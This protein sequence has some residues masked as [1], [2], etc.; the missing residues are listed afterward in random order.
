MVVM[1]DHRIEESPSLNWSNWSLGA[2]PCNKAL[3]S[4]Y[5]PTLLI[6]SA[7]VKPQADL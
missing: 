2:W 7:E 3:K 6:W 4:Y 1:D 5:V